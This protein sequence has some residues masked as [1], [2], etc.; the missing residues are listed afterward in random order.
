MKR[1]TKYLV[2]F[3]SGCVVSFLIMLSKD[4]FSKTALIDI[5]YILTD[6]FFVVGVLMVCAGLLVFSCFNEG[7]F[8]GLTYAVS[9]FFSMFKKDHSRR[10]DT[11]YDY[12]QRR[13]GKKLPFLF[14]I[15]CGA[16]FLIVSTIMYYL[17]MQ[18]I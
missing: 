10:Y 5:Y 17:F 8:D 4:L 9:S 12:R 1:F 2:A 6:S 16:I 18:Q 7:A 13:Q 14:L 11:Y 3:F 15:L